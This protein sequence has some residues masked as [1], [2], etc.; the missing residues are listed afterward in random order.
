MI[1]IKSLLCGSATVAIGVLFTVAAILFR[2]K[3]LAQSSAVGFAPYDLFRPWFLVWVCVLFVV[4]AGV[5]YWR[6]K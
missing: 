2:T 6:L 4:G 5:A 1:W 3:Q